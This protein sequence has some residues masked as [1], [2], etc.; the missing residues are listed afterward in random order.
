M[1]AAL[2]LI[3]PADAGPLTQLLA[4]NRKYLA[5]F[6]PVRPDAFY[7]TAGQSERI[8]DLLAAH[9]LGSA[10]PMVVLD[11]DHEAVGQIA[12]NS[13]IRGAFQS[14]SIAY[15]IS[16][17]RA[18]EGLATA[19]VRQLVDIAFGELHLH[20]VQAEVL[21]HNRARSAC[22]R[23]PASASTGS[24]RHTCTSPASGRSTPCFN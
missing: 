3:E 13:I 18:G 20:R 4:R 6:E 7:T 10:L 5:P 1:A 24:H 22:S 9:A 12:L 15:W 17:D 21:P 23:R 2:R 16:Q 8:G 19:A 14:A 11:G